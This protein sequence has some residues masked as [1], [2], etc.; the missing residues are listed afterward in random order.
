[1]ASSQRLARE[2]IIRDKERFEFV[3]RITVARVSESFDRKG[4]SSLALTVWARAVRMSGSAKESSSPVRYAGFARGA[5]YLVIQNLGV[6]VISIVSFAILAR[7][8]STEEMGIWA[9]LLLVNAT[10]STFGGWFPEAVTKFVAE[11][12]SKGSPT[13]AAAAFYQGLR[14]NLIICLPAVASIYLG[15]AFLASHLL[16][17]ASYAALFQVV[18][19]DVIF[20]GAVMPVAS[21]ASLGLRRFREVAAV[22]FLIGG[23]LRQLLIIS[24]IVVMGNFIGLVIGWVISDALQAIVYL[25]IILRDLGPPRFDFPLMK[26]FRFYLPL[27]LIQT[28]NYAQGWFDRVLLIAYVPLATLGIYNAAVTAF[29]ALQGVSAGIVSMLLP[30]YSSIKDRRGMRDAIRLTS[31]Y[32]SFVV[33]PLGFGLLA[34]AKPS[35]TLLLGEAYAAGSLPLVIFSAADALTAFATGLGTMLLAL[36]ETGAAA[37]LGSVTFLIGLAAA[38][39]LLPLWGTVGAS[40]GRGLAIIVGTVFMLLYARRKVELQLDLPTIAKT[41]VAGVAMAVVIEAVQVVEYSKFL[42]PLYAF[43]GAMVYLIMLRFLRAADTADL[44]L[45]RHFLGKRL[46]MV[47]SVL[48]WI[49]LPRDLAASQA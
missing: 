26:L 42:L 31:R 18:A 28:T 25:V 38:Y 22:G 17:S 46:H 16:G 15:A 34:T 6:S 30:A 14:A 29:G 48:S 23:I 44:D 1:V 39:M 33:T 21:A 24:L 47:S 35:L 43:I 4:F 49:L 2:R 7:L 3:Y 12:L 19:V 5:S 32:A 41:L 9:V 45:L 37:L 11:N 8:I 10:Y 36:E 40:A 13:T 27:E 20:S